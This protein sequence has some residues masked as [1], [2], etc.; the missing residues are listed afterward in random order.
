M[1]H[2]SMKRLVAALA[3]AAFSMGAVATTASSAQAD[4]SWG[5]IAPSHGKPQK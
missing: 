2:R 1:K 5:Q 3:V 4:T